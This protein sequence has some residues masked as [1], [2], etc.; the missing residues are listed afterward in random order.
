MMTTSDAKMRLRPFVSSVYLPG[1]LGRELAEDA[2]CTL[3][4]EFISSR[5]EWEESA[6]DSAR[7][8]C[9]P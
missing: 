6:G 8:A 7:V 3:T 2:R 1:A 5:Q 4:D 9:P